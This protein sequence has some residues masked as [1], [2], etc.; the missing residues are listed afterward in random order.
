MQFINEEV[1]QPESYSVSNSEKVARRRLV[2]SAGKN[3]FFNAAAYALGLQ[4]SLSKRHKRDIRVE[5]SGI[6]ADSIT[7]IRKLIRMIPR[8]D[9]IQL[10]YD[11]TASFCKSI[12]PAVVISR[13]FG[14]GAAL[15][16]Y[17]DQIV[18]EVPFT[19]RQAMSLCGHVYVGTRYLQRKLARYNVKS[20]VM[21]PPGSVDSLPVRAITAVQPHIL[22]VHNSAV[23]SGAICIMRAFIMVKRKFPRT[24]MTVVTNEPVRWPMEVM[25]L[26]Q[27]IQ[28]HDYVSSRNEQDIIR[29]FA[30][31]DLFV[32]F[33]TSETVPS[34]LLVAMAS[35]LPSISFET[36]GAREIIKNGIN[37]L[38]IQHND[39]NQL[40]N[41]IIRL[42][43]EPVLAASISK[44]AV[45]IR[46]RF[47]V[48][49]IV[50]LLQ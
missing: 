5:F 25:Q 18:D 21:L 13:F 6:M 44:E 40:A 15:L 23:D 30:E 50:R 48:E 33:S 12:L 8:F 31:A 36:Y 3:P 35:G 39:H 28:G 2:L 4:E 34:A 19:H 7:S 41:E 27:S 1:L 10:I 43:E 42:I 11:G 17:P 37:G 29:A 49:N 38:L 9:S 14:K 47:S 16:Y 22:L 24:T 46:A 32:N 45:K 26:G 20:E